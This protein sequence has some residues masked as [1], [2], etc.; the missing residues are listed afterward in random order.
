MKT[1]YII[2]SE[3]LQATMESEKGGEVLPDQTPPSPDFHGFG[4]DIVLPAQL[5]IET[6]GEGDDEYVVRVSRKRGKGRPRRG[7]TRQLDESDVTPANIIEKCMKMSDTQPSSTSKTPPPTHKSPSSSQAKQGTSSRP[8]EYLLGK[9]ESSF[10]KAKLPKGK[11]VLSIFLHQLQHSDP[12]TAALETVGQLKEVWNHHFGMRL[13]FGFDS[14]TQ[15]YNKKIISDDKYIQTMVLDMWKDWKE[16]RRISL[17]KDRASKPSFLKKE[18]NFVKNV[19]DMPFKILS[20]NYEDNLKSEAGI[21]AW[22][23]DLQHLHNQMQREQ[24]GT[25]RGYDKKQQKKD[26]RKLKELLSSLPDVSTSTMDDIEEVDSDEAEDD[27]EED[28]D[29]TSAEYTV[30]GGKKPVQRLDVMG[31]ISATADR[32]GLS[33]RARC[34]MSASVAN[35]LGVD[36][37]ETNINR[38]AAWMKAKKERVKMSEFIKENFVCPKLVDVHWDGKMLTEKGNKESNRVAVYISGVDATGFRKLMGCP[39]TKDGTGKSEADVVKAVLEEWGVEK[40]ICGLVFDTTSSNTGCENGACRYLEDWLDTPLLWLAC[41]HHIHEL[42]AKRFVQGIFGQTKDPG[43][44]LFRRLKSSWHSIQIDYDKLSKFD[45]TSVPD[46]MQV[47]GKSVLDWA[48]KELAKKTWPRADYKELLELT[49]ICLG[50]DIPGFKFRLPGPD[51]HARWMSKVIYLLKLFLLLNMFKM[52]EDEKIQVVEVSKYILILYV[53]HWFESPLPTAAARNDLTFMV[54]VLKYRVMVKPSIS[55]SIMQSC[56]RHLWYLVPQ[57]V[58]FAL[59]DPGLPDYQKERMAKKLHSLERTNIQK[60]KPEFPV[61]DFTG[62][63]LKL[64][65]MSAFVSSDSWLVFDLLDLT[66]S[67]DWL[68]IPPSLWSNFQEFRKLKEFSENI[69]VCNDIAERGVSL[70]TSFI[71]KTESE[72]QRQA[73]LQVVEHHRAMVTDTKKSTLKLC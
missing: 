59:A 27:I 24:V 45:F 66:G 35:A 42:H 58:V 23:E 32:L 47:E 54:N 6:E 8:D 55:F 38:G 16:M 49:I 73:L 21:T 68:T 69:S 39:E 64:P 14:D 31:P 19:L 53:K 51:H 25:C 34:M 44:A 9:P 48:L 20:R 1:D 57:T 11:S 30:K 22:K 15:Q 70:I 10:G 50:G 46:W 60:G 17:R 5:V 43:V 62:E 61:I 4:P 36:I 33:V 52:S 72:E 71:N 3:Y 29:D 28:S 63:E 41:R 13:I 2:F 12:P 37:S 56:Y 67:Q 7:D 40:E 18:E 65:D 26:N